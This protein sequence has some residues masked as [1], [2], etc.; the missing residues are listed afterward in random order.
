MGESNCMERP[1]K[2]LKSISKK[3]GKT[4]LAASGDGGAYVVFG[5]CAP[6]KD[7]P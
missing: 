3:D 5:L 1:V 2:L 7:R 6:I 4:V